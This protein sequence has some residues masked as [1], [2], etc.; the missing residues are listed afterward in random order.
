MSSSGKER[1]YQRIS[2]KYKMETT[3]GNYQIRFTRNVSAPAEEQE[4][5]YKVRIITQEYFEEKHEEFGSV[6][7]GLYIVE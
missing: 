7:P 6:V 2:C 1:Y 3:E 5:L 4:G